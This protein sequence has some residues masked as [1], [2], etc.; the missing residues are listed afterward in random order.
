MRRLMILFLLVG[1][2]VVLSGCA[3]LSVHSKVNK[4]GSVES[5]KLVINTSSF[6]YGLLA[7]GAKKEGYE[8]LRES[9]LSE[10]PEEM[11]D[12]VSYDEVWSGDQ[13][14]IIIEARDYVPAD[15]DKV[16]IRK[17]NGFLIYEDLSF[18]SENNQTSSNELGNALL[19]SFSLH[20]YLEMPGKIVESNANVVKDNK[21]EWHLTGASAFNTRIY[22]KSEV[23]GIPGFEAALA[24]VGLLAAGL[25]FGRVKG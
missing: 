19:S 20:Y 8:S 24:I 15:D 21:A 5:Y 9:F 14:S 11:R 13:V 6:V 3:T 16:K 1:L 25:L 12:K 4:D 2:A 10:I 17:E 7:E 18:A 22:A 23:P